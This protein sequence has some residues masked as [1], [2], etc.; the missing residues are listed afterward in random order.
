MDDDWGRQRTSDDR[1]V[2]TRPGHTCPK[3][4]DLASTW[5]LKRKCQ[6]ATTNTARHD[7]EKRTR[8]MAHHERDTAARGCQCDAPNG[9]GENPGD[10]RVRKPRRS[11]PRAAHE[12]F[13]Q[14]RRSRRI[15]WLICSKRR[16]STD[17]AVAKTHG[18]F[19]PSHEP[20]QPDARHL[21]DL[22]AILAHRR[23]LPRARRRQLRTTHIP[24]PPTTCTRG[25]SRT[26]NTP[27]GTPARVL[28]RVA[29]G[30]TA[31]PRP[32]TNSPTQPRRRRIRR[33]ISPASQP[34][35]QDSRVHASN[36]RRPKP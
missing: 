21:P 17:R 11:N 29:A 12:P 3:V 19:T 25:P 13:D 28:E 14:Q 18:P 8:V 16:A 33:I 26:S 15:D 27:A 10:D 6:V 4:H 30:D 22:Q 34:H 35:R 31:T 7:C 2:A 32:T 20:D 36:P 1:I 24:P 5:A 9:V 23:I